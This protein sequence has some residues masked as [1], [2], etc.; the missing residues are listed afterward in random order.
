MTPSIQRM[1]HGD[2]VGKCN[3]RD[4]VSETTHAIQKLTCGISFGRRDVYNRSTSDFATH[5]AN[6]DLCKQA[7]NYIDI[8]NDPLNEGATD[9]IVK[10]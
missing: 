9:G 5:V 7:V 3:R 6:R 8:L 4:N 1:T 2:T 10:N